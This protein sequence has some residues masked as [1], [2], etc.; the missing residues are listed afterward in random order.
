MLLSVT[1]CY[2]FCFVFVTHAKLVLRELD[3]CSLN[4]MF[5]TNVIHT[6][7]IMTSLSVGWQVGWLA[8][9][10][11]LWNTGVNG[12]SSVHVHNQ[13]DHAMWYHLCPCGK[14]T[15]FHL[16]PCISSM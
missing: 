1:E 14:L 10:G 11:L 6:P 4:M 5:F 7:V 12:K 3:V 16:T 8:D 2:F 9:W 13:R 15:P